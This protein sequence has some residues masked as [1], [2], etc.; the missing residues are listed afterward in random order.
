MC[1]SLAELPLKSIDIFWENFSPDSQLS[2]QSDP[3]NLVLYFPSSLNRVHVESFIYN[4]F[5]LKHN[6]EISQYM[7]YLLSLENAN[8]EVLSAAGFRPSCNEQLFLEQYLDEPIEMLLSGYFGEKIY[9]NSIIEVGN[10]ASDCPGSSRLMIM[11]MTCLFDQQGFEWVV[12]TGTNEL[13]NIFRNLQLQPLPLTPAEASRLNK[14]QDKWGSYYTHD[15]Q[16][17]TGNIKAGH[18]ELFKSNYYRQFISNLHTFSLPGC[19]Q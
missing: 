11:A 16:V 17:M 6:A 2:P 3:L 7:P 10:L 9:R 18:E 5:K 15:P 13:L 12:M 4:Q 1:I 14:E 19:A 8:H